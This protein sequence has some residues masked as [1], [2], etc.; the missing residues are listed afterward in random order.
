[1]ESE[2]PNLVSPPIGVERS[3]IGRC[4]DP[5]GDGCDESDA[6]LPRCSRYEYDVD[7]KTVNEADEDVGNNDVHIYFATRNVQV[8]PLIIIIFYAA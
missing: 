3:K 1:M 7:V 6:C 2:I 4:P 8:E 5:D